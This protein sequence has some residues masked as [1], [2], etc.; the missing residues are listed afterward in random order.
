MQPNLV[1]LRD[2]KVRFDGVQVLHGI[3]LDAPGEAVGLVGESGC[4]KSVTWLRRSACCRA[5]QRRGSVDASKAANSA[6]PPAQ[7]W[8]RF[9][10]AVS[11]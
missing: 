5:R 7:C 4:G 8:N 10:A 2:L 11:R 3:D 1:E 9:A 6:A